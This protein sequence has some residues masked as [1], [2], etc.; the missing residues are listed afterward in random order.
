MV[1]KCPKCGGELEQTTPESTKCS[2]C[3][4]VFKIKAPTGS[5]PAQ[6]K[7]TKK[8]E[9][10]EGKHKIL[11]II[12]IV[13]LGLG[14]LG[15]ILP[16]SEEKEGKSGSKQSKSSAK[17]SV[18][19]DED[20]ELEDFEYYVD[21][22]KIHITGYNGENS[23]LK[24]GETYEVEGTKVRVASISGAPFIFAGLESIIVSEGVEFLD[25]TVFNSCEAKYIFI[26]STLNNVE[27]RF[28]DY[29]FQVE[30]LYYGGT[31]EQ[32][33]SIC[34]VEREDIDCKWIYCNVKVDEL[35]EDDSL[36]QVVLMQV[37]EENIEEEIPE[38]EESQVSEGDP[39]D[40]DFNFDFGGSEE[41][42]EP[43]F[44]ASCVSLGYEDIL[45]NPDQ[46]KGQN[47]V[48]NGTVDQIIEG[49]FDSFSIFVIDPNGNKW[50]C[51]YFYKE[52]EPHLLEGDAVTFYGECKGT[53]TTRTILGEQ[54]TMPRID[55]EYIR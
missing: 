16:E 53:D 48:I 15:A 34:N 5:Q 39:E 52:N 36:K 46:Y 11:K 40:Y 44:K 29:F 28:W 19:A 14:I 26:P 41:L 22:D 51:T 38:V 43:D 54:V 23:K 3:G 35:S 2:K 32:W 25:S 24:I 37:P 33:D 12:A 9:K 10:K 45:R 27:D 4:T 18:W 6:K 7:K 47:C 8:K 17:S 30:K 13:V 20:T 1:T 21:G 55:V 49:W 50:G 42:S 31:Q